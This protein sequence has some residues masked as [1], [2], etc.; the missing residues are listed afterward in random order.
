MPVTISGNGTFT[1]T[2]FVANNIAANTITSNNIS[3]TSKLVVGNMPT[4]SV[5]Q[6]AS[7]TLTTQQTINQSGATNENRGATWYDITNLTVTLTPFS[8]SSKF[9][10]F[11]HLTFGVTTSD[12]YNVH[13]RIVRNGTGVG[14]G[15]NGVYTWGATGQVRQWTQATPYVCPYSY[16]DS[17]STASA[18]TYKIQALQT[19]NA[20]GFYVNRATETGWQSGGTSTI[21]VLEIAG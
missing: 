1:G 9:I 6:A 8:S 5:L 13:W 3:S 18:V 16:T 21:T 12:S 10:V 19:Y 20:Y 4:G 15:D 17:P 11:G 14:I 2:S 7:Y